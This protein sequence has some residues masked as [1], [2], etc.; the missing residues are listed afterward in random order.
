M[1]T[2]L[3]GRIIAVTGGATGIG[4]ATARLCAARG[5]HVIVADI[6]PTAGEATAA[7]IREAGG[8]AEFVAVDVRAADQVSALFERID[9]AHGRLDGLVCAAGILRGAFLS[10]EELPL[11]DFQAVQE[12]NVTGVFL[13]V[14]Y[15][16]HLL[17]KAGGRAVMVVISSGAGVVGPSSSL[18]YAASKGGVNGLAL[19]LEAQLARRSIRVNT[20]YPGSIITPMKMRVE[21][22]NAQRKGIPVEQALADAERSYGTPDGV[23][24]LIAFVLSDEASYLRGALTT[25]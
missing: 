8:E 18:A 7:A 20:L 15:G 25:R 21:V 3:A 2:L 14:K 5:A 6:D 4:Q 1:D 9:A 24:R 22:E 16:A 17:E 23:A 13:C 12:V 11:E 10:P 19:T